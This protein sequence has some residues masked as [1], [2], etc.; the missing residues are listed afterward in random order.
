MCLLSCPGTPHLC[1]L[2]CSTSEHKELLHACFIVCQQ[3]W[4]SVAVWRCCCIMPMV[5]SEGELPHAR[6]GL[7]QRIVSGDVPSSLQ[8]RLLMS[9]D[10]G[11]LIAG[12][13]YRCARLFWPHCA[14][15]VRACMI[16]A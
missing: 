12:A 13:K 10:M 14:C 1:S 16:Y 6:A 4:A 9:L 7:A 11:A 15:C 2:A 5:G 3:C 8:D